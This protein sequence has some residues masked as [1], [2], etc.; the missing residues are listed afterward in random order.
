MTETLDHND[1]VFHAHS[2][3]GKTSPLDFLAQASLAFHTEEPEVVSALGKW[4]TAVVSGRERITV[5]GGPSGPSIKLHKGNGRLP[6]IDL[7]KPFAKKCRNRECNNLGGQLGKPRSIYC[8]KRC[9]SREQNLRQGRIKN[10]R[11]PPTQAAPPPAPT[12]PSS[13]SSFAISSIS[14][15]SITRQ[16]SPNSADD[17]DSPTPS[18]TPNT[19]TTHTTMPPPPLSPSPSPVPMVHGSSTSAPSSPVP[20]L[21]SSSPIPFLTNS[22]SPASFL[23]NAHLPGLS[24]TPSPLPLRL[25]MTPSPIQGFSASPIGGLSANTPSPFPRSFSP[26]PMSSSIPTQGGSTPIYLPKPTNPSTSAFQPPSQSSNSAFQPPN[27]PQKNGNTSSA[28][29]NGSNNGNA[30]S[31]STPASSSNGQRKDGMDS[32]TL[33]PILS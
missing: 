18:P 22:P 24:L 11:S 4:S 10:A 5:V 7:S 14:T 9:Q 3:T 26:I 31:N 1:R 12:L 15:A 29:S 20:A 6:N 8:S 32:L 2:A 13:S 21:S 23:M 25:G 27:P 19:Q 28:Q 16:H 33:A 30:T 17:S